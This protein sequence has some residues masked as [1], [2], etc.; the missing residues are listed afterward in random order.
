M[1]KF[2]Q[3]ALAATVAL[4]LPC[5]SIASGASTVKVPATQEKDHRMIVDGI[6]DRKLPGHQKMMDRM[7]ERLGHLDEKRAHVA[8]QRALRKEKASDVREKRRAAMAKRQ[9]ALRKH[10]QRARERKEMISELRTLPGHIE[11]RK[12]RRGDVVYRAGCESGAGR[13]S[14]AGGE[15]C[16]SE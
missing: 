15:R 7:R 11:D 6:P 9:E 2:T 5:A 14:D 8:E 12:D 13:R 3:A 16:A 1:K 10:E 4:C